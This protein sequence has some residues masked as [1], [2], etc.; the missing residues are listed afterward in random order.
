MSCF[1]HWATI[2]AIAD[3]FNVKDLRD[4]K[5]KLLGEIAPRGA[6][7]IIELDTTIEFEEAQR[8]LDNERLK[9]L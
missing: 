3:A 5:E 9:T 7:E 8:I 6:L 4:I 2:S 1:E